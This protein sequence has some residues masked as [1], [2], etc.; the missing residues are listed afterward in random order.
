M[1]GDVRRVGQDA[2]RSDAPPS[3]AQPPDAQPA[4]H[5]VAGPD[6]TPD[7]GEDNCGGLGFIGACDGDSVLMC[8]SGQIFPYDCTDPA[9]S[10]AGP[11]RTCGLQDCTDE[12]DG[13][14]GYFC[15]VKEGKPCDPLDPAEPALCDASKHGCLDGVCA[16]S[17]ACDEATY[18]GQ[19]VGDLLTYCKRRVQNID[20]TLGGT[21]ANTCGQNS[22]G[23][24]VCLGLEGGG[25]SVPKGYECVAGLTCVGNVCT[26][27]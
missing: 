27:P 19:C 17:P 7:S 18:V 22:K 25:C 15:V 20:C 10:Y 14:K 12:Q 1:G 9:L 24:F 16:P 4:D 2:A 13:C 26:A 5:I 3:D 11:D 6:Q 21:E 8:L 23:K